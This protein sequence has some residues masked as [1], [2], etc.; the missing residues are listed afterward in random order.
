MLLAVHRDVSESLLVRSALIV[1]CGLFLSAS[2]CRSWP[3]GYRYAS[4]P[5]FEPKIAQAQ[6]CG[7][8]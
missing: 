2:D 3:N 4:T 1:L 8:I 6:S 5:G 7:E